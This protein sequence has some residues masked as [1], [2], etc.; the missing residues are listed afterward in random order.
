[1]NNIQIKKERNLNKKEF[2]LLLNL[3]YDE[4][5]KIFNSTY[6]IRQI[7]YVRE[8]QEEINE[9]VKRLNLTKGDYYFNNVEI[10]MNKLL[11]KVKKYKQEFLDIKKEE[12]CLMAEGD[13]IKVLN[14]KKL[15]IENKELNM[16]YQDIML[17]SKRKITEINLNLDNH[18]KFIEQNP[19]LIFFGYLTN[20]EDNLFYNLIKNILY[21]YITSNIMLSKYDYQNP[22][23]KEKK[24]NK[25]LLKKPKI[26]LFFKNINEIKFYD[27]NYLNKNIEEIK[28]TFLK[29]TNYKKSKIINN[30]FKYLES[31]FFNEGLGTNIKIH[32]PY[33]YSV[34]NILYQIDD[35]QIFLQ[36]F[37]NK[38]IKTNKNLKEIIL[39][40]FLEKF[41]YQQYYFIDNISEKI[42]DTMVLNKRFLGLFQNNTTVLKILLKTE[43]FDNFV[44]SNIENKNFSYLEK[45]LNIIDSN[46]PFTVLKNIITGNINK[47]DF[48]EILMDN[49]LNILYNKKFNAIIQNIFINNYQTKEQ[50]NDY[51]FYIIQKYNN[52]IFKVN[53]ILNI[54]NNEVASEIK[55]YYIMVYILKINQYEISSRNLAKISNNKIIKTSHSML[56]D[57]EVK[58]IFLNIF[59]KYDSTNESLKFREQGVIKN[60]NLFIIIKNKVLNK[61]LATLNIKHF[62]ISLMQYLKKRYFKISNSE[63]KK[64]LISQSKL[65]NNKFYV[66]GK[67]EKGMTKDYTFSENDLNLIIIEMINNNGVI[68]E[69]IID[70]LIILNI[71][72]SQIKI[73][74]NL[75]IE[76][77]FSNEKYK[78][79]VNLIQQLIKSNSYT[80]LDK[81]GEL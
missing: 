54:F 6:N 30:L 52:E 75:M 7:V 63:F 44:E 74:N 4:Y 22:N 5:K 9:D 65:F 53:S 17:S 70:L 39:K 38:T 51:F 55:F 14:N 37:V 71:D 31:N 60:L 41:N 64:D 46:N 57:G 77:I 61:D 32:L 59:N 3:I 20:E 48:N 29:F 81:I 2:F 23:Y 62:E 18:K 45:K 43:E 35:T 8:K 47:T 11:K 13:K 76:F 10:Y 24:L 69:E 79:N 72:F 12:K 21:T 73:L 16:L 40:I 56:L 15:F 34:F 49:I 19:L 42:I 68:N 28:N 58:E 80:K 27:Y 78:N 25:D 26:K 67:C 1:M 36:K 66:Y 50:K 33:F